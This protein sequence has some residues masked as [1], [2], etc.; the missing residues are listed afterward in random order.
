MAH[1]WQNDSVSYLQL[2]KSI[3]V[4]MRI[5]NHG[6]NQKVLKDEY[7]K[8]DMISIKTLDNHTI[9]QTFHDNEFIEYCK[10][11]YWKNKLKKLISL[12]CM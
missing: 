8:H 10:K 11:L 9:F 2:N 5:D 4:K 7:N 12:I 6:T 1:D 3:F